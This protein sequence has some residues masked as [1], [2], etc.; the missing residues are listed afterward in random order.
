MNEWMWH[1]VGYLI[2]T[3]H[4]LLN[5]LSVLPDPPLFHLISLFLFHRYVCVLR[6]SSAARR[7]WPPMWHVRSSRRPTVSF[8]PGLMSTSYW[9]NCQRTVSAWTLRTFASS[10]RRSRVC[11]WQQ[12]RAAGSS[13]GAVSPHPKAGRGG[14]SVWMDSPATC[15]LQ[16]A[17]CSTRST[18]EFVRTWTCLYLTTTSGVYRISVWLGP[19]LRIN[20]VHSVL[21]SYPHR[22]PRQ[23]KFRWDLFNHQTFA[24]SIP[25][26]VMS[27]HSWATRHVQHSKLFCLHVVG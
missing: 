22:G 16:S 14:C 10:W 21:S 17:S 23:S 2:N 26:T 7:S 11:L 8:V 4:L 1:N 24:K 25:R 13:W 20:V 6:R 18:W 3:L 9:C 15:S 27:S 19:Q 5:E 12:P